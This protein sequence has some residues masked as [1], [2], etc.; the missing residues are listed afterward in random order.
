[1]ME[2]RKNPAG[3]S[4][5]NLIRTRKKVLPKSSDSSNELKLHCT[6]VAKRYPIID[7]HG[8]NGSPPVSRTRCHGVAKYHPIACSPG[9]IGSQHFRR[10]QCKGEGKIPP[11][12]RQPGKRTNLRGAGVGGIHAIR[13]VHRLIKIPGQDERHSMTVTGTVRTAGGS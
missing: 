11:P 10:W 3:Q 5:E 2:H 8:C 1:M 13:K 7:D 4:P 12:F 9:S 6:G